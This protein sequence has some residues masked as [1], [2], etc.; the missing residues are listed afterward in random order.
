MTIFGYVRTMDRELDLPDRHG[1][2]G[3]SLN[4]K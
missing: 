4:V 1:Y 3:S 2:V